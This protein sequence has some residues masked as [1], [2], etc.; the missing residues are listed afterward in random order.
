MSKYYDKTSVDSTFAKSSTLNNYA[1]KSSLP[2]MTKYYDKTT[3]DSTFAKKSDISK[4]YAS[5][6]TTG[7]YRA[8]ENLSVY[9]EVD[10]EQLT[11]DSGYTY[12]KTIAV[13]NLENYRFVGS[14]T[15][16]ETNE[17]V[18]FDIIWKSSINQAMT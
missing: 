14:Y 5:S 17:T 10:V 9:T 15:N 11:S 16:D 1:L 13:G 2:D 6:T 18:N 4:D 7:I 12:A 3:T 8:I